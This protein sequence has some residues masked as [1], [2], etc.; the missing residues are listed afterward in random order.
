MV[1]EIEVIMEIQ[2]LQLKEMKMMHTHLD[3]DLEKQS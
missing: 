2:S 3:L 1:V